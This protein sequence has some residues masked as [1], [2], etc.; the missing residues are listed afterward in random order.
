MQAKAV[1]I[2][3]MKPILAALCLLMTFPIAL[4][5]GALFD[6]VSKKG[7]AGG[8][9]GT[10]FRVGRLTDDA[11]L[12]RGPLCRQRVDWTGGK[13]EAIDQARAVPRVV[14][15]EGIEGLPEGVPGEEKP[16]EEEGKK[17]P[18]EDGEEPTAPP[19]EVP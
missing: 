10:P 2:R 1:F 11:A 3:S 18:A 12:G 8:E 17:E 13:R 16:A 5:L 15:V 4:G 9:N 7:A 14:L 6:Q 19:E